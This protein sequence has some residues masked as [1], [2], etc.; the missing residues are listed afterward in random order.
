M[1]HRLINEVLAA[2]GLLTWGGWVPPGNRY[3]GPEDSH[4]TVPGR[5]RPAQDRLPSNQD[6]SDP[7]STND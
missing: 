5:N 1:Y 4:L 2:W 3:P 6:L 7:P